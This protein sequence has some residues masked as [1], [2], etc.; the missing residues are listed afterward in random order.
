[1]PD[2]AIERTDWLVEVSGPPPQVYVSV[3]NWCPPVEELEDTES[4]TV[5]QTIFK[6]LGF[7]IDCGAKFW[8]KRT[9]AK[10]DVTVS[11]T[12]MTPRIVRVLIFR[13]FIFLIKP[14]LDWFRKLCRPLKYVSE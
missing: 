12:A 4:V 13:I 2:A 1:M 9:I 6:P 3:N 10:T 5:E 8:T 11:E 7:E 14:P